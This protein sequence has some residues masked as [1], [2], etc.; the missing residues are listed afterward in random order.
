MR[1]RFAVVAFFFA[2]S[3][4]VLAA[5][6]APAGPSKMLT[7]PALS[8]SGSRSS[9]ERH[10]DL[11]SR[12]ERRGAHHLRP[13]DEDAARVQPDGSL[14]AFT[15]ELDGNLD[16]FVV[17]PRRRAEA[18]D[19][20]PRPRRRAGLHSRRQVRPLHLA[21]RLVQ[22]RHTQLYTVPVEGASRRPFRFPTPAA[23]RTPRRTDDRLQPERSGVPAVE[24]L[25]RRRGLEAVALRHRL[26]CDRPRPQPRRAATTRTRCGSAGRSSSVDRDGEFNLYAYDRNRR[27]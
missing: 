1:I 5:A 8:A 21:A 14:L 11:P 13:G 7:D 17:P 18:P 23:P 24:A 20:A 25:P 4:A 26:E 27:P 22:Q 16:V 12:R 2:I 15:A 10:L 6:G 9:G 19:V 3:S